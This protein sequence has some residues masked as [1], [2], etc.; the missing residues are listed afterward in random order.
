[1]SY[2]NIKI[3]VDMKGVNKCFELK[4]NKTWDYNKLD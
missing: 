1:M 3:P 4:P 2:L